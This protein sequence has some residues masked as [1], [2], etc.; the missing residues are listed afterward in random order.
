MLSKFTCT[1][2]RVQAGQVRVSIASGPI[3]NLGLEERESG[4]NSLGNKYPSKLTFI[5]SLVSSHAFPA[6]PYWTVVGV[7]TPVIGTRGELP[8]T[9]HSCMQLS[10]TVCGAT[11]SLPSWHLATQNPAS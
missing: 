10:R 7:Y 5:T 1:A 6:V 3:G 4:A 9:I 2:V 11:L 8:A